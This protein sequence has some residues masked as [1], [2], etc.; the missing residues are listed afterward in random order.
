MHLI[1]YILYQKYFIN[2]L[3]FIIYFIHLNYRL[4]LFQNVT[5]FSIIITHLLISRKGFSGI[6]T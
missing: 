1:L 3:L 5:N 2:P 4:N 6:K